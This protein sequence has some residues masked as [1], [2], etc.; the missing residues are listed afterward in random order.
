MFEPIT[1]DEQV[2]FDRLVDAT[3]GR[4]TNARIALMRV[5]FDNEDAAAVVILSQ[6]ED[7]SE[8]FTTPIALL[9]DDTLFERLTPPDEVADDEATEESNQ[10]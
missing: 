10:T 9:V 2:Q 7:G 8:Q 6:S 4:F 5:Q 3:I 1:E